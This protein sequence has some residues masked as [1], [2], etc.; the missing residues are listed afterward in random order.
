MTFDMAAVV[1]VVA[2]LRG[3]KGETVESLNKAASGGDR[4]AE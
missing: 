2:A 3:E 1:F 4:R